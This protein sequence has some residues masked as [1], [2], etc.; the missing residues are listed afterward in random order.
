MKI[1]ITLLALLLTLSNSEASV[2]AKEQPVSNVPDL[3]K[4]KLNQE[5]FLTDTLSLIHI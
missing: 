2:K 1:K 4:L 3:N 5:A